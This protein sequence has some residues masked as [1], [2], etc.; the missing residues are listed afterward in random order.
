MTSG[1]YDLPGASAT[2]TAVRG[3]DDEVLEEVA[4]VEPS[5]GRGAALDGD[6]VRALGPAGDERVVVLLVVELG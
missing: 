1:L 3:S 2:A 6:D 4:R 5:L